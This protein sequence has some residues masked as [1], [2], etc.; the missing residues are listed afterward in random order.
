M[1]KRNDENARPLTGSATFPIRLLFIVSTVHRCSRSDLFLLK[2]LTE[3]YARLDLTAHLHHGIPNKPRRYIR[4]GW[5]TALKCTPP[6]KMP[7]PSSLST[8]IRTLFT[9]LPNLSIII[10][11]KTHVHTCMVYIQESWLNS[12]VADAPIFIQGFE[13]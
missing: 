10:R 9:K 6:A 11:S 12:R 2:H 3:V 13:A 5:H 8:N 1:C 4:A 7:V